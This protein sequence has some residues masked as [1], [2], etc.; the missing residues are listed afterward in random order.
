MKL[1]NKSK[2]FTL[3]FGGSDFVIPEGEFE[4]GNDALGNHI[5]YIANKWGFDVAQTGGGSNAIKPIKKAIEK[6]EVV[7]EPAAE[8]V[9]PVAKKQGRPKKNA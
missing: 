5:L 3:M 9:E 4:V 8:A 6:T 7:A 2:E 1:L